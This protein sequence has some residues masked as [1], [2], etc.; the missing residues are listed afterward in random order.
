ME[1]DDLAQ[2]VVKAGQQPLV[3]VEKALGTPR[4]G[5]G[6]E[7]LGLGRE[8]E[9]EKSAERPA[10]DDDLAFRGPALRAR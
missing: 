1:D 4:D 9:Q 6:L 7:L 3:G 2:S 5:P 10:H 8:C